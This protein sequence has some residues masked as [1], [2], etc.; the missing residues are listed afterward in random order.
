MLTGDDLLVS[1]RWSPRLPALIVGAALIA[2]VV[3]AFVLDGVALACNEPI[4][5]QCTGFAVPWPSL[6]VAVLTTL[7]L[8]A[9]TSAIP[10][11]TYQ[12]RKYALLISMSVGIVVSCVLVGQTGSVPADRYYEM[13]DGA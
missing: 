1:A 7:A 4:P 11:R 5:P 3:L 8:A 10:E 9:V 2:V 6:S 12:R 13:T